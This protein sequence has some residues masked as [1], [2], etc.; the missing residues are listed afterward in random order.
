MTEVMFNEMSSGPAVEASQIAAPVIPQ[1]ARAPAPPQNSAD[2]HKPGLL[3]GGVDVVSAVERR[4]RR[5]IVCVVVVV[6]VVRRRRDRANMVGE[7]DSWFGRKKYIEMFFL[8]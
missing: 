4:R 5:R 3:V 1:P 7:N 2:F 6:V 8:F